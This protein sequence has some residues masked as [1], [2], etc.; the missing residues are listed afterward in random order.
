MVNVPNHSKVTHQFLAIFCANIISISHGCALGWLS[1]YLPLL[2]SDSSPLSTGS[3]SLE[4]TSWIGAILCIGGVIGNSIFGYLCKL[5]GRKRAI[6]LLGLPNLGF[7]LC[8][9]FGR[10]VYHLYLARLLAGCAGG[11]LYVCIPLFVSEIAED[12]IRG[13]LGSLL[14]V[15]SNIGILMS[16]IAGAYVKYSLFPCIMI[17][18]PLMFIISFYFLPETPQYLLQHDKVKEA[19]NALRFYRNAQVCDDKEACQRFEQE[20]AK[21]TQFAKQNTINGEGIQLS[22]FCTPAARRGLLIGVM[23]MAIN[24][25]SG[26]FVLLNYSATIFRDSGSDINPNT[27]SIIMASIQCI[28]TYVAT[29]LV[30]KVGRKLLLT[31]SASATTIGLAVMGTYSYLDHLDFDLH[32]FDWVPVVSL[33]FVIFIASIGILPLPYIVLAEVLPDK[34]RRVGSTICVASISAMSFLILKTFPVL[35]NLIGLY[36]CMWLFAGFCAFGTLFIVFVV[37]ETKGTV[38]DTVKTRCMSIY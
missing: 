3:I 32:H 37:D 9:M 22:D 2:Q 8:I 11:G 38:L 25:F 13:T 17:V 30:D 21:I 26:C 7:W 34:I 23:L 6:I 15:C 16:F 4:E 19:E 35:T 31:I 20:L 33:S 10:Y 24:Q 27:S 5:I 28:G 1:P 12:R 18:F 36:G 29:F 14:L